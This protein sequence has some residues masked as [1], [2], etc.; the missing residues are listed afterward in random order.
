MPFT[1]PEIEKKLKNILADKYDIGVDPLQP[2][3][4][5]ANLQDEYGLDSLDFVELIMEC[6]KE[7]NI[8]IPDDKAEGLKTFNQVVTAIEGFLAESK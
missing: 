7:F 5:E 1:K 2:L 3:K 6:E 4:E 8:S